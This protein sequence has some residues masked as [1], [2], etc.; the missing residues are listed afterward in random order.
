M[1]SHDGKYLITT[2]WDD[3]IKIWNIKNDFS[4]EKTLTNHNKLVTSID[5]SHNG[6]YLVSTSDDKT[7]KIFDL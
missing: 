1:F 5:F 6:R 4:L 3:T 7:L 2:S